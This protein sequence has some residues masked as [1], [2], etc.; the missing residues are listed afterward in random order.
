M[1]GES[2]VCLFFF[3]SPRCC[4]AFVVCVGEY[5][6]Y[7]EFGLSCNRLPA[8]WLDNQ[9]KVPGNRP[10]GVDFCSNSEVSD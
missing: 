3:F 10:D 4:L 5:Q 2:F 1:L 6:V 7:V 8:I 9:M